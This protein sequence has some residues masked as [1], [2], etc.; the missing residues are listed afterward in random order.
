MQALRPLSIATNLAEGYNR[1]ANAFPREF[2]SIARLGSGM[3]SSFAGCA[4]ARSHQRPGNDRSKG[5]ARNRCQNDQRIDQCPRQAS[6]VIRS[7]GGMKPA[8]RA[9]VFSVPN[10][11][12]DRS[13]LTSFVAASPPTKMD[14]MRPVSP[15]RMA[16]PFGLTRSRPYLCGA[17]A[18]G[19]LV[20]GAAVFAADAADA[21]CVTGSVMH[22]V[23]AT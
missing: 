13:P 12:E 5:R 20:A 16:H 6:R 8:L 21:G 9:R 11:R 10:R 23:T 14:H 18:G 4:P 15:A 17:A 1:F 22:F 19:V 2:F 3:C 7:P